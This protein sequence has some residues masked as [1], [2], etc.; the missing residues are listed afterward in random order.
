MICRGS[1]SPPR[2]KSAVLLKDMERYIQHCEN[3]TCIKHAWTWERNQNDQTKQLQHLIPRAIEPKK[4][5][6]KFG[7]SVVAGSIQAASVAGSRH[8]PSQGHWRWPGIRWSP[9]PQGM[10]PRRWR[11]ALLPWW[12]LLPWSEGEEDEEGTMGRLKEEDATHLS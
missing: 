10:A 3:P 6:S 2:S 9:R 12:R 7:R 8:R 4:N 11:P 1:C 5:P